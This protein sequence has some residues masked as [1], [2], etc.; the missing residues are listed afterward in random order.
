MSAACRCRIEVG[1]EIIARADGVPL[2]I[3]ELGKAV[4]ESGVATRAGDG[5]R[6]HEVVVPET[7]QD[8]L[9]ARLDRMSLA[10]PVAQLAAV[11]GRG[12]T[13]QL[14]S[15]VAP[16]SWQP[17]DTAIKAL[18]SAE[19]IL[20]IPGAPSSY[21]FKHA[22]LQDVAYNSL[23]RTTRRITTGRSLT[24]S[25]SNS[26]RWR[27]HSLKSSLAISP[28]PDFP[29]TRFGYWLKAG[30]HATRLSS[31]LDAISRISSAV[32]HCLIS[33][34]ISAERARLEYR[35][36]L[37][38]LTPLIAAKGYTAPELERI[39]ERALLLSEE[40]GDT[41]KIF[42]ALYSRQVFE[43]T[44]G[45]FDRAAEHAREALQ[46]AMRNPSSDSAPFA[47]R[48]FATLKVVSRRGGHRMR[49][50]THMLSQY[51]PARHS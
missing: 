3:E 48:L 16:R 31:N 4:M 11:L 37:A 42:P 6:Q 38:L 8:L 28:R 25:S 50:T 7:L 49:A 36:C 2:F 45:Q 32:W 1:A 20:P 44:R 29:M 30:E 13:F 47:G 40:I 26:P 19:I 15:A 10:K 34:T 43:L 22:L 9:M 14:L 21:Q 39:F 12:F 51:D 23:L 18:T 5:V 41:E 33:S 27:K 46:L 35:F 17:I 24:L